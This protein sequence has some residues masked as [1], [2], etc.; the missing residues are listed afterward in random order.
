MAEAVLFKSNNGSKKRKGDGVGGNKSKKSLASLLM[1]NVPANTFNEN[2][3]N[4]AVFNPNEGKEGII[5]RTFHLGGS[6]YIIFH[7]SQGLIRNIYLKE[8]RR[9]SR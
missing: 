5:K 7:G 8:W 2:E 1:S 9:M 4:T 6:K 3:G